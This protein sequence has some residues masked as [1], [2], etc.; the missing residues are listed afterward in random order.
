VVDWTVDSFWSLAQ[1][2]VEVEQRS[3]GGVCAKRLQER[4]TPFATD[5]TI[6]F[7]YLLWSSGE[8]WTKSLADMKKVVAIKVSKLAFLRTEFTSL[9]KYNYYKL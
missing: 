9:S 1:L 6:I 2:G 7:D 5:E 8:K 3:A 4:T